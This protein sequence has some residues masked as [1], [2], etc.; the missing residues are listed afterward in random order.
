[1]QPTTALD[2]HAGVECAC[3]EPTTAALC[4]FRA[5]V[6]VLGADVLVVLGVSPYIEHSKV[7]TRTI[8]VFYQGYPLALV[9]LYSLQRRTLLVPASLDKTWLDVGGEAGRAL[10][11]AVGWQWIETCG[12]FVCVFACKGTASVRQFESIC[13][14][15][16]SVR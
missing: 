4:P 15:R 9:L 12:L 6:F 3:N 13:R 2:P 14:S 11:L 5:F 1:M 10:L 8:P 16:A 7:S